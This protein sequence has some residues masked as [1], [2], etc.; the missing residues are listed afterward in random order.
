MDKE[1]EKEEPTR[2]PDTLP[3]TNDAG[4]NTDHKDQEEERPPIKHDDALDYLHQI[5]KSNLGDMKLFDIQEQAM[6][7]TQYKKIIT[8][9]TSKTKQSSIK[10]F[11]KV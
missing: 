8:K 10:S 7:L 6:T 2:A 1:L 4:D 9:L 5:Q 3:Y 11:L